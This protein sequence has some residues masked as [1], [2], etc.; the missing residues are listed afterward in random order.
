MLRCQGPMEGIYGVL[1]HVTDVTGDTTPFGMRSGHKILAQ[2]IKIVG[3]AELVGT[4]GLARG[5][6]SCRLRDT[7]GKMPRIAQ[8]PMQ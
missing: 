2:D 6:C 3:Y 1:I 4:Q 7:F 8:A 5:D